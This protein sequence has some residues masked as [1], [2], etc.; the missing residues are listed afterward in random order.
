MNRGKHSTFK[1]INLR[2]Q[3]VFITS[4]TKF[5]QF[6]AANTDSLV[7]KLLFYASTTKDLFPTKVRDEPKIIPSYGNLQCTQQR[8]T[9]WDTGRTIDEPK[10]TKH[11]SDAFTT[12]TLH[13]LTLQRPPPVRKEGDNFEFPRL[14]KQR[15][16]QII[17][18]QTC[19][20]LQ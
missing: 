11:F 17:S 1:K 16:P 8:E 18:L 20:E 5:P 15:G 4:T 3:I 9:A 12:S 7:T 14:G 2:T 10:K 19:F 13:L 6:S